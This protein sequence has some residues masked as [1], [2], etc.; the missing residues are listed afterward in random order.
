MIKKPSE[1]ITTLQYIFILNGA[2]V[3]TGVLSLPR[4]LAEKA[5]TDGWMAIVLSWL[6]GTAAGFVWIKTMQQFPDSSPPELFKRLYGSIV[7]KLI[8]AA[9]ALYFTFFVWIVQVK[10][11]LYIKAWLL[12]KTPSY[13]IL[14]LFAVPTFMVASKGMRIVGRLSE[15]V[16][17]MTLWM[18]LV[19]FIPLG[20][21]SLLHLLPLF[22]DGF[23]PVVQAVELTIYSMIGFEL[24][25]FL[26]PYLQKKQYAVHGMVAAN[27]LTMLINLFVTLVCFVYFSPSEIK[28]YNQPALNFLKG[29]EFRFLERF[30][31][32]FL[33]FYLIVVFTTWVPFLHFSSLGF[34]RLFGKFS[35]GLFVAVI[36]MLIVG[37]AFFVH[38]TW[39]QAE[40]WQK[41]VTQW[42][43]RHGLPISVIFMGQR[44]GLPKSETEEFLV[45]R[46]AALGI[47]LLV[48]AV[49]LTGCYDQTDI[50]DV[51][52]TLVLG[53][54][55]DENNRLLVYLSSPVFSKEAK[56]KEEHFGVKTKTIRASRDRFDAM[57]MGLTTG[58]KTNIFLI[59][60]RLM[61][62]PEWH[63]YLDP[64][65]RDPKNK[66]TPYLIV[67]NGPVSEV[68]GYAPKDKPRLPLF[69]TKL[70]KT[71]I[72]RNVTVQSTIRDFHKQMVEE[73]ITPSMA[74][75]QLKRKLELSGTALLDQQG[76]YK[77][78]I[79]SQQTK[80]LRILQQKTN[81]EFTFTLSVP[82]SLRE[83]DDGMNKLSLSTQRINVK[84]K[85]RYDKTFVF[86]FDITMGVAITERL[87]SFDIRKHSDVSEKELDKQF[88]TLFQRFI[89]RIQDAKI[90]PIGLGLY[91]RAYTY[92]EWKNVQDHWGEALSEAKINV[93]VKTIIA[94]MGTIS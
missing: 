90:D 46:R 33:G 82:P 31:M 26:Y 80:L 64:Y 84:T 9:F 29:I 81:G 94:G 59:G 25:A 8:T 23:V 93:K 42:G 10:A 36:L 53:M 12:P 28:Q 92:S 69:L 67:V 62:Q 63:H 40:A 6:I 86:D 85:V 1:S 61:E 51:S 30:D 83:D 79:D 27:T 38:P 34:A 52:L 58:S 41:G 50:E 78:T 3:G 54:D 55:A 73:G 22:K 57:V 89:R 60:K 7:G 15:L 43:G 70:M 74:E 37:I 44:M 88:Q 19:F 17:Y 48:L 68:I 11:M 77:L 4:E 49:A 35:H 32:I 56:V 47:A 45:I 72:R 18:P 76:R 75:L 16:V 24:A 20:D 13:L 14:L 39:N 91:A 21:G 87:F 71:A 65:L 2:Q 66:V 5:G